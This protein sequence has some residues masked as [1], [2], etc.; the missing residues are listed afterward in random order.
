MVSVASQVQPLTERRFFTWMAVAMAATAFAGFARTYYLSGFHN[1]PTPVLTP[2]VHIHGALATAWILVLIAQVRLIAYRRRDIHRW[3]G[4]AGALIGAAAFVSGIFVALYSQ[5]RQHTPATAG[6]LADPYVFLMFPITTMGLF[7][8]FATL[9]VLQ[10]QRP[11]AHKR[12][13]LLATISLITPALARLVTQIEGAIGVVGVPG[14]VGAVVLMNLFLIALVVHDLQ[15]RGRLHPVTLWAGAVLVIS[16]PLR[17]LI[18]FSAPW[19]AL[20]QTL[21]S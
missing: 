17:F 1:A 9:G 16:E 20:A 5:R 13:M 2:S 10:R 21:M 8:V 15:T 6:T 12:F 18:G 19:Q 4:M 11:E 7:A 14:V 3:V